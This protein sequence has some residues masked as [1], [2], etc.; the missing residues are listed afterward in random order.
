MEKMGKC[1]SL[2]ILPLIAEIVYSSLKSYLFN[3]TPIWNFEVTLF[4]YGAFF[5]LGAA[6]CHREKK[7][8]AVEVLANYVSPG[9][10]KALR[11]VSELVVLFVAL[12][13]LYAAVPAAYKSILI[14]ERSM[15]QT[16]FNPQVWW[17]KCII[18]IT[19]AMISWQSLR[20]LYGIV[21]GR[22]TDKERGEA[23]A[24]GN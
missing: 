22:G 18:P 6:Y 10:R 11:I 24:H 13:I 20:D 5:M 17:F 8:V 2:L 14:R 7:H 16:P 9:K 3:D 15:H 12:A 23:A 21:T 4:L 19:C 1:V